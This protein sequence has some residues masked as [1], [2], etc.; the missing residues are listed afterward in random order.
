VAEPQPANT[1]ASNPNTT[2]SQQPVQKSTNNTATQLAPIEDIELTVETPELP[3]L[4][5]VT[6]RNP[7]QP[8][9]ASSATVSSIPGSGTLG[10]STLAIEPSS[11]GWRIFGIPW[12]WLGV[13]AAI[14]FAAS[15]WVK[16]R[17]AHSA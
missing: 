12:Y 16:K 17:Y 14:V 7:T 13:V 2:P 3:V 9:V 5:S 4:P 6:H 8:E 1:P 15:I 11:E 10:V